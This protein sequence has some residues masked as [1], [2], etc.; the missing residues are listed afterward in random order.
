MRVLVARA[1][2]LGDALLLR[3]AIFALRRAGHEGALLVPRAAGSALVGPGD[4]EVTTALDLDGIW[5]ADGLSGNDRALQPLEGF[6]AALALTRSRPFVEALRSRIPRVLVR[7]PEPASRHASLWAA[8]PL[9][10]LGC[11]VDEEVPPD[12]LPTEAERAAAEPLLRRLGG[13]FIAVHPGSGSE[14]KNWPVE[15]FGD[16]LDRLVAGPPWLLICGPA[17]RGMGSLLERLPGAVSVVDCPLRTLAAVLRHAALFVGNDS[18]V[19]HLAAASG[20]PV[21]ALF[22]PT[23]PRLWAPVGRSVEVVASPTQRMTGL[24]VESVHRVARAVWRDSLRR[25]DAFG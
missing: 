16:L 5:L 20:A 14:A 12:L 6:D 11:P 1:G 21:V 8:D 19:S 4:S 2:A 17:E 9:R 24:S 10:S 18:G 25:R 22:G 3:R 7:D 23:D 15:S 13:A